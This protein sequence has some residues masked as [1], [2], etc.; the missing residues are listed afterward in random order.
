MPAFPRASQHG[1][2]R[3][4]LRRTGDVVYA[5][6]KNPR[7]LQQQRRRE[8]RERKKR[9]HGETLSSCSRRRKHKVDFV[10]RFAHPD[11][12]GCVKLKSSYRACGVRQ[13]QQLLN[14]Q[15][16]KPNLTEYDFVCILQAGGGKIRC[17][18]KKCKHKAFGGRKFILFSPFFPHN[19]RD[20]SFLLLCV[21]GLPW[22]KWL[23][24]MFLHLAFWW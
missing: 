2:A 9:D 24:K 16:T 6:L 10:F 23:L 7:A 11:G 3:S 15:G 12:G 17:R 19:L 22:L 18:G 14:E 21:S 13:G 4:R 8:R 5:V 1:G 20:E